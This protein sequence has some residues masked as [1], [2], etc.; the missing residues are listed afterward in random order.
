[1]FLLSQLKLLLPLLKLGKAGGAIISMAISVGAYA[2]IY[3]WQFAVGVVLLIFVHELGHV[4]A[5]KQKGLPVTRRYLF[6]FSER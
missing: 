6:R 1:M 5:A 2:I 4:L 3:P